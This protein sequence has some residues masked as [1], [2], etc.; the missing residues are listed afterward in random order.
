MEKKNE[1]IEKSTK[2]EEVELKP[3][4]SKLKSFH[5]KAMVGTKENGNK[6]LRSF[7]FLVAEITDGKVKINKTKLRGKLKEGQKKVKGKFPKRQ[8]KFKGN[9][10]EI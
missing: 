3:T 10:E 5:G 7:G 9:L 8:R 1:K 4:W 6:Y 2:V